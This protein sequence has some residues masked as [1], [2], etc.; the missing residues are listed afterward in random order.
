MPTR[1]GADRDTYR[2]GD[3]RRAAIEAGLAQLSS[4]TASPVTLRGT[5]RQIGVAHHALSHHF[6]D[7]A[8]FERALAA[9]GFESLADQVE[10]T[11]DA[12]GFVAAYARFALAH[13]R[14]YDVMMRQPYAAFEA[15]PTLRAAS[16][17]VIGKALAVLAPNAP[18]AESGRR[19]VARAWMLTHGG[20]SLHATGVLRMR[21]DEDFV[22]E[23]LRIAGLAPDQ[24]EGPQ[25]IWGDHNEEHQ[26]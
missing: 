2:H 25:S 20:I 7:K 8:G 12:A 4:E 17:R 11:D 16:G 6:V 14:L 9:A 5:A 1:T 10:T 26:P 19:T 13:A 21:S 3:V 15:D 24:P 23:L 18:D 22:A